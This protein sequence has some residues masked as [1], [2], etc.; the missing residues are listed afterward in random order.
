MDLD[1]LRIIVWNERESGKLSDIPPDLF[2]SARRAL[3]EIEGEIQGIADPFSEEGAVLQDRYHSIRETL[4]TIVKLRLKKIL[5]L[6][7]A[8]IEGGYIDREELKQMNAQEHG[9]FEA[10]CRE[11]GDCR[12]ALVDGVLLERA[13][14]PPAAHPVPV[15]E[16]EPCEPAEE[17]GGEDEIAA[18]IDE[19]FSKSIPDSEIPSRAPPAEGGAISI[20]LVNEALPAFMGLDGRTYALEAGDLVTLPKENAGVLCERNIALNIRLIK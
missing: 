17:D 3:E 14:P 18:L 2:S 15:C 8:Q 19:A 7:E 1:D 13:V 16:E 20:V 10:V 6:A 9:M 12:Q 5:R 4:A 11:I